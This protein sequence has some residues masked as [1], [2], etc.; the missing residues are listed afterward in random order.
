MLNESLVE[1]ALLWLAKECGEAPAQ[2]ARQAFEEATGAIEEG[3]PDYEARIAHFLEQYLCDG[4]P[5]PIASFAQAATDLAA[6]DRRELA[7]WLRSHRSL[8][9]CEGIDGQ[10]GVVRDCILGG[11]FEFTPSE[12]DRQLAPGEHF[13]GRLV[14]LGEQLW[15]SPGRVYHP[16][17]AHEALKALLAQLDIDLLPRS[18]LLNGLLAMRSRFLKFESVRAEHVYQARALAPVHLPMRS[19]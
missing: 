4:T 13:D 1:R 17:E 6:P 16:H 3:A 8:F 12:R 5:A 19:G 15:L 11:R 7:G 2:R 14:A 9:A 18:A 10:L